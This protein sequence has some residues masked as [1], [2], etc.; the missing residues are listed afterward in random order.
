MFFFNGRRAGVVCVWAG[1][2]AGRGLHSQRPPVLSGAGVQPTMVC[3]LWPY[4]HKPT[5]AK[6]AWM[7][8]QVLVQ[9]MEQ[10]Q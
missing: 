5:E 7:A 3:S 2:G 8:V 10:P 1:A 4:W 6:R 9:K